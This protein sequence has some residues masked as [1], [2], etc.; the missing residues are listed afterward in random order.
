MTIKLRES[1]VWKSDELHVVFVLVVVVFDVVVLDVLCSLLTSVPPAAAISCMLS[2]LHRFVLQ[3]QT[4]PVMPTPA[5]FPY[6]FL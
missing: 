1:E 4:V 5:L 3:A 2:P 6:S